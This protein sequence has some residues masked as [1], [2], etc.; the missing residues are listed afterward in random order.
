MFYFSCAN[1]VKIKTAIKEKHLIVVCVVNILP[2]N[3]VLKTL[4]RKIVYNHNGYNRKL[5]Q[6]LE[7]F[8]ENILST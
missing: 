7:K 4:T 1:I 8:V 2:L 5:P 3:N 6:G